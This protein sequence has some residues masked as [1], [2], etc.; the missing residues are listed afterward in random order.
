MNA[1]FPKK[2]RG[3]TFGLWTCHQYVGDILS[4]LMTAAIVNAGF[5]WQYALVLPGLLSGAWGV[6][7]FF[8][9]PNSPADVGIIEESKASA[10]SGGAAKSDSGGSIGF[11]QALQIPNVLSYAAA[12]GFFK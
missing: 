11:L 1:G 8:C 7:N 3:L 5:A 9:L 2:G 4:G 10:A 6:V 12:F